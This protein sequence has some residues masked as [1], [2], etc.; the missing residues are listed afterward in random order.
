MSRVRNPS[1]EGFSSVGGPW[2]RLLL[3]LERAHPSL[4]TALMLGSSQ[5]PVTTAPGDPMLL[6]STGTYTRVHRPLHIH[7]T[8]KKKKK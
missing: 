2:L 4:I 1:V 5:S 7:E 6:T 3:L 8:K